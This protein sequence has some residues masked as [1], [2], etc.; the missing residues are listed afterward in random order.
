MTIDTVRTLDDASRPLA[1]VTGPAARR[2]T[3]VVRPGPVALAAVLLTIALGWIG[4]GRGLVTSDEGALLGQIH[5]VQ[6]HDTWSMPHP[7]PELDPDGR[8]FP[9]DQAQLGD[10]GWSPLAKHPLTTTI[11]GW[12]YGMFG[13][14]GGAGGTGSAGG[15]VALGIVATAATVLAIGR[16]ARLLGAPT[17]S[18]AMLAAAA[19]SPLVYDS[20]VLMGHPFGTLAAASVSIVALS[21]ARHPRPTA[22][23]VLTWSALGFVAAAA[24]P[25]FRNEALL[26]DA[27]VAVALLVLAV[28]R[29]SIRSACVG[30]AIAAGGVMGY[31]ADTAWSAHILGS[32]RAFRISEQNGFVGRAAGAVSALLLPGDGGLVVSAVLAAGLLGAIV[33]GR[34]LSATAAMTATATAPTPALPPAVDRRRGAIG[35]VLLVGAALVWP[36]VVDGS[37]TPGL[38]VACPVLVVGLALLRRPIDDVEWLAYVSIGLCSAAVLATQYSD[39]G[40]LQWGGRYLHV[41]MPL[42]IP[43]VVIAGGNALAGLA[44]PPV[45]RIVAAGLSVAVAGNLAALLV[46]AHGVRRLNAE[47]VTSVRAF[48][49]A[50]HDDATAGDGGGPIIVSDVTPLGRLSWDGLPEE[51]QLYVP[52]NEWHALGER[53]TGSHI[54]RIVVATT[55]PTAEIERALAVPLTVTVDELNAVGTLRLLVVEVDRP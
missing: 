35:L 46:A 7:V 13:G 25:M 48:A 51:R 30:L 53:L 9:V 1:E 16:I 22:A 41:V 47:S 2:S 28:R 29:R 10:A 12:G 6:D 15:T 17:G 4:A 5:L 38:L 8:W 23:T 33:V 3:Q 11:L 21:A 37:L 50:H 18:T 27:A 20:F 45:R 55:R 14:A 34:A 32:S 52:E 54:D 44:H 39:G 40:G 24:G 31:L 49:A 19:C 42:V 36:F 26:F 43:L